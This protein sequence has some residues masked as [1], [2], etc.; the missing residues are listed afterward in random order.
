MYLDVF[1]RN[2]YGTNC[3]LLA[4]EGSDEVVVIDPGFEPEAVHAMLTAAGKRPAAVLLTHAHLDHAAAAGSFAQT[5]PVY[6]HPD[7]V[8]AF[9]DSV[10]WGGMSAVGLDP[11][12]V[13]AL[14][15]WGP[16]AAGGLFDRGA[17]HARTHAW[18]LQ[19]PRG[20]TTL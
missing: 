2:P 8:P 13:C 3:W 9:S 10:A 17:A 1:D 4:A 19:L 15:G 7:D 5:L 11:A 12:H 18:V 14:R 16:V 20:R 6:I